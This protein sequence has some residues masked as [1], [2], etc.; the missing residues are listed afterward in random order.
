VK[1]ASEIRTGVGLLVGVQLIATFGVVGLLVRMSPVIE[2]IL[3]ENGEGIGAIEDMYAAIVERDCGLSQ[4][5]AEQR[6]DDAL[7]RARASAR[8][9]G[10]D[11]LL[12]DVDDTWRAGLAGDCDARLVTTERLDQLADMHRGHM[13]D[14]EQQA[15]LLGGAGAWAAALLGLAGFGASV[16][17]V[18]RFTN[19]LA[20]PLGEIDA[21]L[22]AQSKGD[23]YRRCARIE[24]AEEYGSISARLNALFDRRLAAAEDEDPQLKSIDR[25]LLHHL[26]DRM[27]EPAVAVDTSGAIIAASDA[28][29]DVLAGSGI[30]SLADA[31]AVGPG[32]EED[33]ISL[34]QKVE[35]FGKQAGFLIT[36][37]V[38]N[39]R[40]EKEGGEPTVPLL[41]DEPEHAPAVRTPTPMV[42]K[43]SETLADKGATD[44]SQAP[45]VVPP[46]PKSD[47]P[48]WERD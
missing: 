11:Q 19:R 44:D 24:A 15:R 32:G 31:L 20:E 4:G 33:G 35:P 10:Q 45:P 25:A 9:E 23:P 36:L 2:R 16:G 12:D 40:A 48:D 3:A 8:E 1:A 39:T 47:K 46:S 42:I 5:E 7:E 37:R 17:L 22:S 29:L 21:V 18:R 26:L 28:A 41:D 14:A 30:G 38:L 34:I 6:F 27:P 43:R 13:L